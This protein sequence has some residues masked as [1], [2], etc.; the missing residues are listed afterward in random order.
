MGSCHEGTQLF[1]LTEEYSRA[2]VKRE[3]GERLLVTY[4][5]VKWAVG[6]FFHCTLLLLI[7][8]L[9]GH[10]WVNV[11]AHKLAGLDDGD[12]NLQHKAACTHSGP[13]CSSTQEELGEAG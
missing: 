1:H 6:S 9:N 3:L 2:V 11:L 5:I 13:G 8:D 10:D 4:F 12:G 7:P